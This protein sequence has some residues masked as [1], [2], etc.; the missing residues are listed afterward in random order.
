MLRHT[1]VEACA[2]T[3][4]ER[5]GQNW[6]HDSLG[7]LTPSSTDIYTQIFTNTPVIW[8]A[9]VHNLWS[10]WLNCSYLIIIRKLC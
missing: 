3:E 7:S 5:G 8:T 9:V 4:A 1:P 10:P 6:H 2:P